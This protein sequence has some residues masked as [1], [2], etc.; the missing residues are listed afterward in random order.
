MAG[1]A[2]ITDRPPVARILRSSNRGGARDFEVLTLL[3]RLWLRVSEVAALERDMH[4]RHGE[5][6]V[7]GKGGREE[8]LPLPTDVGEA[9]AGWL[10]HRPLR[11]TSTRVFTSV[12][13]RHGDL[14][15]K[16]TT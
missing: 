2:A 1:F 5:V 16:G 8:G 9:I 3:V 10:R 6:P 15:R 14:T 4:W 12:I 11:C 13:A 7:R